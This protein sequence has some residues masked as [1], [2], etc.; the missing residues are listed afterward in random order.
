MFGKT[1][2][3]WK[4]P[5]LASSNKSLRID[6]LVVIPNAD[7]STAS[8]RHTF[9]EESLFHSYWVYFYVVTAIGQRTITLQYAGRIEPLDSNPVAEFTTLLH[10][11]L[12]PRDSI[13][14]P[15]DLDG[16]WVI[17]TTR[18]AKLVQVLFPGTANDS[19]NGRN[20]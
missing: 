13:T 16:N 2:C 6:D 15:L 17:A 11:D 18:G 9:S 10:L 1:V 12:L 14:L 19:S 20:G 5:K 3:S 4:K 7:F 8:N